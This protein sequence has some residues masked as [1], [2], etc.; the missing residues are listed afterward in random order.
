M[1]TSK[2]NIV[3]GLLIGAAIG[4][5]FGILYAPQKGSKTRRQIKDTS[6]DTTRDIARKLKHAKDD[7]ADAAHETKVEFEKKMNTIISNLSDKSEAV[8]SALEKKMDV[9]KSKG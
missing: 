8:I 9:L 3:F 5:L 2:K 6:I 4:T 1:D 7:F